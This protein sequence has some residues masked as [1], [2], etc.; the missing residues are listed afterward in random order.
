MDDINTDKMVI[1]PSSVDTFQQCAYQWYRVFILGG[2]S[3]PGSRAAIGTAIHRGAEEMWRDSMKAGTV[4]VSKSSMADAAMEAWDEEKQKGLQFETGETDGTCAVEII[5]GLDTF[6][7]DIVPWVSI[8]TDVEIRYTVD[9]DDH[10]IVGAISGTIDYLNTSIG[11]L[12]D[13][14]TGK[15]KHNVVNSETQQSIYHYLA[16]ENGVKINAATIQNVVLK[17]EPEGHIMES[18]INLPKA[19]AAVNSIL[20]TLEVYHQDVMD[21]EIL[22]RGN[23]KYYLCSPK[24]CAFYKECR[25]VGN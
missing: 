7:D 15:R 22:F 20:D 10:P 17:K 21:P 19:K 16:E 6:V 1:R 11:I 23:P 25:Y 12:G 18:S 8:P 5:Q 9:I 14:K 24:Y 4:I 13:I 2:V 3:I